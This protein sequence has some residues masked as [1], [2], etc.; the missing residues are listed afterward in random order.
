MGET[1]SV[2]LELVGFELRVHLV[3][4]DLKLFGDLAFGEKRQLERQHQAI[5]LFVIAETNKEIYLFG[6][7]SRMFR[8]EFL[9]GF[10]SRFLDV[11]R[12]S[13]GAACGTAHRHHAWLWT[14]ITEQQRQMVFLV[15]KQTN[16]EVVGA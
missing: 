8:S 9:L 6:W 10:F 12:R 13:R 3:F 5:D 2:F 15:E 7:S 1:P 14:T 16:R 4:R 11:F